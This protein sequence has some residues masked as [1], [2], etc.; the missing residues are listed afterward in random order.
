M[1][2]AFIKPHGVYAI[3]DVIEPAM[4]GVAAEYIRRGLCIEVTPQS[5]I[6]AKAID[7]PVQ[8]KMV[9]RTS[10]ARKGSHGR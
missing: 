3:G 10:V 1:K 2:I 4:L 8:H 5:V 7:G 9:T 6:D